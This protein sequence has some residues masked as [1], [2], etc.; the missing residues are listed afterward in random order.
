[1]AFYGERT[2]MDSRPGVYPLP[3]DAGLLEGSAAQ[4]KDDRRKGEAGRPPLGQPALVAACWPGGHARV[5]AM[6]IGSMIR[7]L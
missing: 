6:G 4:A 3:L 7:R 1:M 5:S 2:P